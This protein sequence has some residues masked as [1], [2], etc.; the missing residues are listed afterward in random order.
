V[1][2]KSRARA[3]GVAPGGRKCGWD[4]RWNCGRLC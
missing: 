3:G 1:G 4:A 2:P